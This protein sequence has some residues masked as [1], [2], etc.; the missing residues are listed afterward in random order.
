MRAL[1]WSTTSLGH[2]SSW[3]HSLSTVVRVM[4]NSGHPMYIFWGPERICLYNDAYRKSIGPERHPGSLG[5]P[6]LEVWSEIWDVIGPQIDQVMAGRGSTWHENQLIPITRNGKLEDVYWTY[7]Y[8][9]IDDS[10]AAHGVGGVLVV[11]AETTEKVLSLQRTAEERERF[12][13]L[14]SIVESSDDAIVSKD[15]NGKIRSWNKGAERLFGYT[16][17]EVIGRP[18]TILI[19]TDFLDEEPAILGRIVKGERIE[20]YETTRQRKDGSL[21]HV[22]LTV[23]PVRDFSGK[24]IGASKVGRDITQ[25]RRAQEK[26]KLLLQEMNHRVKNLFAVASGLIAVSARTATTPKQLSSDVRSR[27]GALARAQ[28]LILAGDRQNTSKVQLLDLARTILS[29]YDTNNGHISISGPEV[30]CGPGA[31]TSI[32]LLLHEF[33]TNSVKYGALMNAEGSIDVRFETGRQL[34]LTWTESGVPP[35]QSTAITQGFGGVLVDAT[36]AGLGGTIERAWSRTDL[37]IQITVP[38][39]RIAG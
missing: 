1:D 27:L 5:R 37:R 17:Q 14:A 32:A 25:K 11:C 34:M 6:A 24:I 13:V 38:L 29:P 20:H 35:I 2:P 10:T 9:P 22:S 21:I 19:P 18:V 36:I 28:D 30:E 31:A 16:A 3:P 39:E 12:A 26:Q 8:S 4:L 15:L 33:A 7:S 23:S